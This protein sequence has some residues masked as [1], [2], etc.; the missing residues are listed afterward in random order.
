MNPVFLSPEDVLDIHEE[1]LLLHGG[2]D[3]ILNLTLLE[4][5]VQ[6]PSAWF[7][8]FLYEDIVTMAAMYLFGINKNHAFKDGNK[9][10]GLAASLTFLKINGV[11][12]AEADTKELERLS[13]E[14]ACG[15][16]S[17]EEVIDH[18]HAIFPGHRHVADR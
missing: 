8:G 2:G 11:P 4:S 7:G 14:V 15:R 6:Q 16:M 5:A 10:T 3:G 18:F 1:Q 17:K 9:R 12:T 13:L